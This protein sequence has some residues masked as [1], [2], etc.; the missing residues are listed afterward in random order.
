MASTTGLRDRSSRHLPHSLQS[1]AETVDYHADGQASSKDRSLNARQT[2]RARRQ[3]CISGSTLRP[4][5]VR[6]RD[7]RPG[8]LGQPDAHQRRPMEWT[9][10]GLSIETK[11][12]VKRGEL[13][14]VRTRERVKMPAD[15]C[16]LWSQLDRNSRQGLLVVNSSVVP[17]GYEGFLT[18]TFVN[19]GN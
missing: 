2:Q 1:W 8:V 10:T 7:A 11:Y 18:C 5:R 16:G 9:V 12:A 19:F 6:E 14:R 17:A 15:M 4:P 3:Q 13:V